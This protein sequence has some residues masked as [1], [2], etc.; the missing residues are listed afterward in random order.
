MGKKGYMCVGKGVSESVK[1]CAGESVCVC[2]NG[3]DI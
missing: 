2:V 1:A 3:G